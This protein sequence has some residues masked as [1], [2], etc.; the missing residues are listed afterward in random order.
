MQA[1]SSI[2]CFIVKA[3]SSVP[4]ACIKATFNWEGFQNDELGLNSLIFGTLM[5]D[6]CSNV[7]S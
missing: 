1:L 5:L 7:K 3:G 4:K 2:Q 6:F